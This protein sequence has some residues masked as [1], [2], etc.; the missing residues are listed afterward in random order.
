MEAEGFWSNPERTRADVSKLKH[1]RAIVEPF[2]GVER[3]FG[4]VDAHAELEVAGGADA[5]LEAELASTLE[6]IAKELEK[7]EFHVMLGGEHDHRGCFLS[8]QAGADG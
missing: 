1:A 8:I 6:A 2:D 3:L 7:I 5:E 4:D